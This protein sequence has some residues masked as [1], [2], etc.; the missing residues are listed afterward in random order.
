MINPVVKSQ[1]PNSTAAE[2]GSPTQ[3]VKP[4]QA[5]V[6]AKAQFHP[7]RGRDL[8]K[9]EAGEGQ[10]IHEAARSYAQHGERFQSIV[11]SHLAQ[12]D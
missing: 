9:H 8:A 1:R 7:M 3:P 2:P 6:Q 4:R 12:P 10:W 5:T 11:R